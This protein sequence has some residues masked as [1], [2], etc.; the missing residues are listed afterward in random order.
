M[1]PGSWKTP[2]R[3]AMLCLIAALAGCASGQDEQ[4]DKLQVDGYSVHSLRSRDTEKLNERLFAAANLDTDPGDYLLGAGD[5]LQV[6]VFESQELNCKVRVS[7]R[8]YITLPLLGQVDVKGM[9]AREAEIHIE[10]LY[11]E[12]YLQDPH[13]SVFVEAHVSQRVT[14]LGQVKNPGTY[15]YPTKLRLMDVMALGGGLSEQAG[16]T[17]QVR[18]PPDAGGEGG[19]DFPHRPG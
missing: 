5:L 15:D 2:I 14:L 7:S 13:V 16:R 11:G 9:S 4:L 8:G 19:G 6:T 3:F 1:H 17:V 18:R 10:D 12:R